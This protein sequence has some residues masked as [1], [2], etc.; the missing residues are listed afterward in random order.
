MMRKL[1]SIFQ[2]NQHRISALMLTF[3]ML[4]SM[5]PNIGLTAFAMEPTYDIWVA[6]TQVTSSNAADVLGEADGDGATVTYDAGTN[7]LILNG[8]NISG[9]YEGNMTASAAIY[10]AGYLTINLADGSTNIVTY[11]G[12]ASNETH[13]IFVTRGMTIDGKGRLEANGGTSGICANN[14]DLT[15]KNGTIIAEGTGIGASSSAGIVSYAQG[16][17]INGGDVT[18]TGGNTSSSYGLSARGNSGTI[19]IN[20]GKVTANGGDSDNSNGIVAKVD[21]TIENGEVNATGVTM[22]IA[23]TNGKI[24]INGGTGEAKATSTG[25]SYMAM[26]KAPVLGAGIEA[27]GVYM[28]QT[29]TWITATTYHDIWVAGT[30]VTSDNKTDVLGEADGAGATVTYDADSSTLTLNGANITHDGSG[31]SDSFYKQGAISANVP[32]NIVLKGT[33]SVTN[34]NSNNNPSSYG[35]YV[36]KDLTINGAGNLTSAGG[37]GNTTLTGT[38]ES[39]GIYVKGGKLTIGGSGN[40]TA[41]GADS[42]GGSYGVFATKGTT[43]SDSCNLTATGGTGTGASNSACGICDSGV[44]PITINTSGT[45]KATGRKAANDSYGIYSRAG[46]VTVENGTVEATGDKYGIYANSTSEAHITIN[47]GNVT[48]TGDKYGIYTNNSKSN[49]TINDGN[50]TAN[51]KSSTN[52]YGLYSNGKIIINGGSGTATGGIRAMNKA[53][54]SDTGVQLSGKYSDKTA[55][56]PKPTSYTVTYDANGGTG[57]PIDSTVRELGDPF[58]I[59]QQV[60]VRDG[61]FFCG[62]LKDGSGSHYRWPGETVNTSIEQDNIIKMVAQWGEKNLSVTTDGVTTYYT[63]LEDAFENA[64]DGSTITVEKDYTD[65]SDPSIPQE[66]PAKVLTL[67]LNEKN[68]NSYGEIDIYGGKLTITGGGIYD[69]TLYQEGG[70]LIIEDGT[71]GQLIVDD[72]YSD[73]LTTTLNGGTFTGSLYDESS[74]VYISSVNAEQ[75]IKNMLGEGKKYSVDE[76]VTVEYGEDPDVYYVAYFQGPVSV[77]DKPVQVTYNGNDNTGGTAP[78]DSNSYTSGAQ[79]TVLGN[80]GSLVKTGYTFDG[81]NTKA[82]GTGTAYATGAQFTIT[83]DT[84]LY[85]KWKLCDHANST[86]TPTCTESAVCSVCGGTISALGHDFTGN[87][88]AYNDNGH[89]HICNRENCS[90][91]DT[92][93]GHSFTDYQYNND[94]TYQKDGTETATCDFCG[95][96]N[97]R[98]K[99]GTKLPDT[100][101]PAGEIKVSENSWKEFINAITFGIFCNDKYDVVITAKDNETGVKSIEYLL[102]D[103]AISETDIQTKPGWIAYS[104]FSL[105]NEGKYIIYAKITDNSGNVTY[106]SS[107]GLVLDNIL[108]AISGIENDKTYCEAI[109][110]TVDEVYVDTVTVNGEAVTLADGKFTVAPAAGEQTIVVTD[111]AGNRTEMTITVNDGHTW[112]EYISNHDATCTADG[113]KTAECQ[114]CDATDTVVDEGSM[115]AHTYG[116]WTDAK[117]GKRHVRTCSCG[118]AETEAHKWDSGKV[119]KEATTTEKGEKTYT[120]AVCGAVKKE[121]IPMLV[122]S[123]QTGDNMNIAFWFILMLSAAF[124][125]VRLSIYSKKK[126]VR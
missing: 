77:I 45:V 68:I 83:A 54:T 12:P 32:L 60:P 89:W 21:V 57:A 111:K 25:S 118:N 30:Q 52:G 20:G 101:A 78:T 125:V 86:A 80:T 5:L 35:I 1:K 16:I 121:E 48:A 56:W 114:F 14:G 94:A 81:W 90:A 112:G 10:A 107:Q 7:T 9:S 126:K 105:E 40:I 100:T 15:I 42:S 59:P 82:D 2:S 103:T 8:A 113:T 87:F 88:D 23:S 37:N 49:I 122:E 17:I 51:G 29:M 53:H 41:T 65:D 69:G 116:E 11:S 62:W 117:D 43:I 98:T 36:E 84:N 97:T 119:T 104:D 72:Y 18:A 108:P 34:T 99:S 95:Q 93:V 46:G 67:N 19:T 109:E 110:V 123:P 31:S 61:Y 58:V 79:V 75:A 92:S 124:G 38:Y 3:C 71:F 70:E 44:T 74:I 73:A 33:N 76:I 102:S 85:A 22:G 50:V 91:I 13:G 66:S 4:L 63:T 6:G 96:Q 24:T 27:T 115:L 106:I 55:S 64:P 120:C 28:D 26:N 39:A 47:G